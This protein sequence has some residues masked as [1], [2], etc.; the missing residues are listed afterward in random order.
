MGVDELLE[1]G[2]VDERVGCGSFA[3]GGVVCTG[4]AMELDAV[5]ADAPIGTGAAEQ[6]AD[7]LGVRGGGVGV[8]T[9]RVEVVG[10]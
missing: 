5:R 4:G 2:L 9:N 10:G 1:G 3:A 8:G 7:G 6:S